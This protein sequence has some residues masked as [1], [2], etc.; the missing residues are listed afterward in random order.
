MYSYSSTRFWHTWTTSCHS[1]L[2]RWMWK[3]VYSKTTHVCFPFLT[4]IIPRPGWYKIVL[5]HVSV[6]SCL[7]VQLVLRYFLY[8]CSR[9]TLSEFKGA[10]KG[11]AVIKI[12]SEERPVPS[13][14]TIYGIRIVCVIFNMI[15]RITENMFIIN[16]WKL[17]S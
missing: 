13:Q 1:T 4:S 2:S 12:C 10:L 17:Y 6:C 9:W 7:P 8:F 15:K 11:K 14:C 3:L 5:F 16:I